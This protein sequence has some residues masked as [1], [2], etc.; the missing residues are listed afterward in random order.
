MKAALYWM[1]A[2]PA[3]RAEVRLNDA[4]F[5]QEPPVD[6]PGGQGSKSL[7]NPASLKVLTEARL[8]PFLAD[9]KAG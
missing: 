3:V 8:E 6:L 9:T 4:L 2:A 5:I 1:I 7:L